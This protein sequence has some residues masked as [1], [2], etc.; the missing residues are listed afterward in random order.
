MNIS[1]FLT[2]AAIS[3]AASFGFSTAASAA[4]IAIAPIASPADGLVQKVGW[5]H[6]RGFYRHRGHAFY[7]GHRGYRHHRRG[8]RRHN[9]YY[10]PRDAFSV[11][12]HIGP[13]RYIEP[14]RVIR[15]APARPRIVNVGTLHVKWCYSK[16]RS[17]RAS[18]NTFQP[19]HGPRKRCRSPY[20][21]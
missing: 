15:R 18:D 17:Y 1:R 16:Y 7:N 6:R 10:F 9:G 13:R 19:Y 21:R 12:I 8:Y 20:A 2:A 11:T 5:E 4:P 14:R 3:I